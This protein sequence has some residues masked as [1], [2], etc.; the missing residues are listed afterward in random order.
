MESGPSSRVVGDLRSVVGAGWRLRRESGLRLGFG[1]RLF[2]SLG[3]VGSAFGI[4]GSGLLEIML[5]HKA[6][7][8][9]VDAVVV[10][11]GFFSIFLGEEDLVPRYYAICFPRTLTPEPAYSLFLSVHPRL[12]HHHHRFLVAL[13]SFSSSD[14]FL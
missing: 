11:R 3:S 6:S 2:E 4:D 12:P 1:D 9:M 14:P 13:F 7:T 8:S 10:A 5:S